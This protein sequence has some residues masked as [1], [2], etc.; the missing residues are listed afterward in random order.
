MRS[1]TRVAINTIAQYVRTILNVCIG[2]FVTRIILLALGENDFGIYSLI[3]GFVTM[4]SFITSAMTITT[5]RFLSFHQTHSSFDYVKRVFS[6]SLII[7]VSLSAL[8]FVILEF[9]G[10]FLFDG[11]LNIESERI[12]V[13]KF[14]YH[15]AVVMV[16]ISMLS[17]PYAAVLVAHENLVYTS[18]IS[19]AD[20]VLK[21]IM[22][23]LIINIDADR[24]IVYALLMLFIQAFNLIGYSAYS[25]FKYSECRRPSILH[26][27]KKMIS[28]IGRF[29]G[30]TV[31]GTGCTI[32]RT[33][34]IAIIINKML[35][36]AAN[37]AF[38][39][40]MQVHGAVL[41]VGSS[42]MS[43]ITPQIV[44]SEGAGDRK[45]ML[46]LS[47]TSSKFCFLLLSSVTIPMIFYMDWILEMWLKI[48][49]PYASLFCRILLISGLC[50]YLTYGLN[51]ANSA[52]GKIKLYT[53]VIQSIKLSTVAVMTVFIILKLPLEVTF[54]SY[55]MM[56]LISSLARIP[57]MKHQVGLSVGLFVKEA[58]IRTSLPIAFLCVGC[59]L[60]HHNVL[61]IYPTIIFLLII[62]CLFAI[63]VYS[64][65]MN[66][67][68]RQTLKSI[69]RRE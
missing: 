39:V 2:L 65:A 1:A 45:R 23:Y 69:I 16:V 52:I 6:N 11:F 41:F 56:E 42:L 10:L 29:A 63:S 12:P 28:E 33:Q 21:L 49:P 48:V 62:E 27:S 14:V 66:K 64:I 5:Q 30:W 55:A 31:Y 43:A 18:I 58:I 61:G 44:K 67:W 38:G 68:E 37:A 35:N 17:S 47:T 3:A 59:S 20:S 24:L 22:A 50:D 60:I 53:L 15:C 4:L 40:A 19:V 25:M 46:L 51:S 7:H 57:L 54:W 13:A 32:G 8:G 9:V 26:L 36:T 34:G